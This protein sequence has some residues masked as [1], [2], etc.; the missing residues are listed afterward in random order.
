M[1]KEKSTKRPVRG[2]GDDVLTAQEAAFLE[3]YLADP[4]RNG[5]Q[6]AI[7]AGYSPKGA[8]VAA[9]R[10][11]RRPR[12]AAKVIAAERAVFSKVEEVTDQ[13][14]ITKERVIRELARMAFSDIRNVVSF[15]PE[16]RT[17]TLMDGSVVKTSGVG[18]IASD[19]LSDDAAAAIE[20]IA[21]GPNGIKVKLA[22]KRAALID[23]AKIAGFYV[24][25]QKIESD[26]GAALAEILSGIQRSALPINGSII[27][28]GITIDA[29]PIQDAD[30]VPDP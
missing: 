14:V 23:L 12:V 22:S 25:K 6:A 7:K 24:E 10:L 11:L 16:H 17:L 18:V 15:G 20:E 28:S 26:L 29:S 1:A 21:E 30:E 9:I 4:E 3:H 8:N 2:G 27:T 5:T 19:A 13:L